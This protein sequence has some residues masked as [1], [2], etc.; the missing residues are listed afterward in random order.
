MIIHLIMGAVLYY[1]SNEL[2]KHYKWKHK[3]RKWN[4][5]MQEYYKKEG[6]K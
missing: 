5:K 6:K 1:A 3:Q 4:K 2:Y